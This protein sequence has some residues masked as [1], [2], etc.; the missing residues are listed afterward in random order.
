MSGIAKTLMTEASDIFENR[1]PAD[2]NS[3]T[4][5]DYAVLERVEG[6]LADGLALK[7]WWEQTHANNSYAQVFEIIREFNKSDDSFGFFDSVELPYGGETPVMGTVDDS[8]Y[9][10][11]QRASIER[12]RDEFREFVLRYFM[13]VS[14]YREPQAYGEPRGRTKY[15]TGL[16]WCPQEVDS[17]RGFG[18][19]QHYYKLRATG[20]IGKFNRHDANAI[21]DLREIGEKYEWIVLKVRIFNF[22]V[23]VPVPGIEEARLVIPLLEESYLVVNRDFIDNDDA[24]A[25]GVT[26]RYG[27]GYAFIRSPETGLLAYGPGEF[28]AAIE[29]IRFEARSDGAIRARLVF[30][31]NR[32]A[33]IL[34]VT[35]DPIDWSFRAADFFSFGITKPFFAP[36]RSLFQNLPFRIGGVD[37]LGAYVTAANGFTGGAAA[38]ELCISREQLEKIFLVQ[39]FMQHYQMLVGSLL[40]WRRIPNW[41]DEAALPEYVVSGRFG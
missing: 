16:S 39:H 36:F 13:R 6:A 25:D 34:N 38:E 2:E 28:G 27:F 40:T 33:N 21:V 11:T 35:F 9:D 5:Q 41:L 17:G 15:M 18:F 14:D 22:N 23:N 19:T 10:Y 29:M 1:L 24:P 3:L 12:V 26:G 20:E 4:A 32:P 30:L 7:S 8:L 37:P 31:V